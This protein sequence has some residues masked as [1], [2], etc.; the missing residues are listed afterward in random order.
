MHVRRLAQRRGATQPTK[1]H[2]NPVLALLSPAHIPKETTWTAPIP[3]GIFRPRRAQGC[4]S[5]KRQGMLLGML[6]NSCGQV[7]LSAGTP[8]KDTYIYKNAIGL[9]QKDGLELR[10][11]TERFTSIFTDEI[12]H[13]NYLRYSSRNHTKRSLAQGGKQGHVIS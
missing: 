11:N 1:N 2:P 5:Q 12:R 7:S 8:L 3:A 9:R 6:D 10:V 4:S 13:T